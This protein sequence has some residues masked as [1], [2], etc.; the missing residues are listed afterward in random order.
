MFKKAL[1]ALGIV[2]SPVLAQQADKTLP[3]IIPY[4]SVREACMDIPSLWEC[5]RMLRTLHMEN[6][7]LWALV[8]RDNKGIIQSRLIESYKIVLRN[9]MD[10]CWVGY[11][12]MGDADAEATAAHLCDELLM[13]E[14]KALKSVKK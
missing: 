8:V 9:A 12:L 6:V 1:L 11:G 2:V 14:Y 4:T 5:K 13:S 7:K 10:S 3:P